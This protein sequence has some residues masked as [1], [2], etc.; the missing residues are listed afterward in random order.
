MAIYSNKLY[1]R[2]VTNL[3]H[4]G[5]DPGKTNKNIPIET[6]SKCKFNHIGLTISE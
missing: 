4:S 2:L 6:Y 5:T 3:I 1:G